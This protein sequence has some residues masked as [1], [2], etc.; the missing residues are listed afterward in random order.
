MIHKRE[1]HDLEKKFDL[2]VIGGGITGISV[3]R[4]AAVRGIRVL[5]VEK[6]DFACATSSATSKL[7]HGGLRYLESYEFG[8]VRE[9]LSERHIMGLAAG[10][11][12]RPMQF[13]VPMF[14]WSNPGRFIMQMGLSTYDL[15]AYD[16]NLGTPEDKQI[17]P[18]KWI[19]REEF[20]KL[21]PK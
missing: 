9:S 20:L 16:R 4:E 1:F 12:S 13:L 2:V 21:E 3:A 18:A 19:S 8:L 15:L 5:C 14:E 7:L 17:P 10:H 6:N 11:L